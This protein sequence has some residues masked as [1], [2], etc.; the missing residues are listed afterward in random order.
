MPYTQIEK[1]HTLYLMPDDDSVD[2]KSETND[3]M[4]QRMPKGW[5]FLTKFAREHIKEIQESS[6]NAESASE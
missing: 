6:V 2:R 5:R 3:E 4:L 1:P